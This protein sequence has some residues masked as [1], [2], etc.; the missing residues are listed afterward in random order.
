[1]AADLALT[2]P[3]DASA[4]GVARAATKRYS[5]GKVH[6]ERISELILV[7]SE[8]VSNAWLHGRGRSSSNFRSTTRSSA[9]R[10]S[11][12]GPGSSATVRARGPEEVGGRGLFLVNAL[13]NRWGI[14][15]GTTHVWLELQA[16]GDARGRPNPRLGQD[17]R[18]EALH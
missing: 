17:A 16:G 11:T 3:P 10:S 9:A 18:P 6:A 1:M 7:I 15:E 12:K 8:L 4:P 13:T 14:H 5:A 2:L